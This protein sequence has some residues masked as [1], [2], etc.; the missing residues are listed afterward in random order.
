MRNYKA[1]FLDFDGTLFDT[2]D[3][4]VGVYRTGFQAIGM[5]CT[6]EQVSFYMHMSL[7]QTCDYLSILDEKKRAL[8]C[9]K[10]QEALD[11]PEFIAQI[12]IYDDVIPTLHKL[13]E[14]KKAIAIVSGNT[15]RH[16]G[17]VLER[18]NLSHDFSFI[19]G[20]SPLRRSKPS[21]D[22][23]LYAM[24]NLP[25]IRYSDVVYVGDSLQDPQT[26]IA[27]GVDGIL[28]ERNKE[29]PN[30]QGQ[31]ISSLLDLTH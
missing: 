18:F 1:Y 8:F 19:V 17:L 7:A 21:A 4:L 11:Y 12:K 25:S 29:Y 20:S 30:Y 24:K 14:K 13:E 9:E 26:A 27:G 31:K 23:I 16:I 5:D 22:P 6:K 3:S 15:E 2:L 28:L 10:V